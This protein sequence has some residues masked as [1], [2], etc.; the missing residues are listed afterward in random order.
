MGMPEI[1]V[2][3]KN[4]KQKRQN[5]GNIIWFQRENIVKKQLNKGIKFFGV[6]MILEQEK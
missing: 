4:N 1:F 2:K 3:R 5:N 6:I